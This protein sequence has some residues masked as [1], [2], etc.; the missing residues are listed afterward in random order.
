VAR[1]DV[2]TVAAHLDALAPDELA[3][4]RAVA[5]EA[6]RVSCRDDEALRE[7]LAGDGS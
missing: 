6:L 1:G 2:G 5:L 7:L 4:Y 3:T